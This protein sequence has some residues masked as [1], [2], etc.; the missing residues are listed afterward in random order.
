VELRG[1]GARGALGRGLARKGAS[2]GAWEGGR[3]AVE[4][5][6]IDVLFTQPYMQVQAI[7]LVRP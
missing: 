7:F 3:A 2:V 4:P 1:E 5:R 6:T